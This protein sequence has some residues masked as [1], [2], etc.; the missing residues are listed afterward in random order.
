MSAPALLTSD[1]LARALGYAD[2]SAVHNRIDRG[3]VR[4]AACRLPGSHRRCW[5]RSRLIAAGFLCVESAPVVTSA[6]L[7][8]PAPAMHVATWRAA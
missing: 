7:P 1:E 4:L 6:A 8:A 2:R 3:D 5:S